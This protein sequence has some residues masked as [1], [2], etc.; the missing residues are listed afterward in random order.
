MLPRR[1]PRDTNGNDAPFGSVP[2]GLDRLL[3]HVARWRGWTVLSAVLALLVAAQF[4]YFSLTRPSIDWDTV[5]Y[6]MAILKGPAFETKGVLDAPALHAATWATLKPWLTPDLL[7]YMTEGDY[8]IA[9]YTQP[10]ALVS[11]L[12]LFES[13]YGYVLA[14]KAVAAF[15]S[16][17]Q[18]IILASLVG[19]LGTLAIVF[20]AAVRLHGIA[21]LA[22]LPFVL[23]FKLPSFASMTTPDSLTTLLAVAGFACLL[24][25]RST[26]GIALLVA[27]AVI[28]PDSLILNLAVSAVFVL[29]RDYGSAAALAMLSV[30]A[31]LFNALMSGHPGW[32]P[33]FHY[34]FVAIQAVL[35]GDWPPFEIGLYGRILLRQIGE[36]SHLPWAHAGFAATLLAVILLAARPD[37][38]RSLLLLAVLA[39]VAGRFFLYPSAELRLYAPQFFIVCLILLATART[40]PSSD[41]APDIG[42]VRRRAG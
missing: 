5:P 9:Q 12:P 16:P 33:Q 17:V 37:S 6:T 27:S 18:A 1:A 41:G 24:A 39:G 30:A 28:R 29:R 20:A 34:N 21:T 35:T 13:K 14:L 38:W 40:F 22:W 11:Q 4:V 32:W 19:A 10:A 15:T 25:K 42:A 36:L 2:L 3:V 7:A 31:Y 8:R 26:P 23:L